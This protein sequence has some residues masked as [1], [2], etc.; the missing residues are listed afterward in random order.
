MREYI[1]NPLYQNTSAF[2]IFNLCSSYKYQSYGYYVSLLA[3]ARG[4][5]VIPNITTIRDF[6]IHNVI[7]SA[8]IEVDELINRSLR[9][10]KLKTFS[11]NIYFGQTPDQDYEILA[12]KLYHLF[13]APLFRVN[14]I[15]DKKWL[16]RSIKILKHCIWKMSRRLFYRQH[17]KLLH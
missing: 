7:Q 16:I 17:K 4:Q 11:L 6:R 3:S 1:N 2:R 9:K 5:R 15:K 8:A 10:L 14:F 12:M 13:E